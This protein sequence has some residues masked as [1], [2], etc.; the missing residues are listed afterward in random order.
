MNNM[1][2]E[3]EKSKIERLSVDEKRHLA[4]ST[5]NKLSIILDKIKKE[6]KHSKKRC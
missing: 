4:F 2:S 3:D 1:L 6:Q 5:L